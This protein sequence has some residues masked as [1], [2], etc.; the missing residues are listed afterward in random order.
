MALRQNEPIAIVRVAGSIPKS[1][2]VYRRNDVG[3]G[4]RAADMPDVGAL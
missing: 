1:A 4:E 2:V 3:D